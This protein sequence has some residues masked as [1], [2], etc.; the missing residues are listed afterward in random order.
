MTTTDGTGRPKLRDY[1][2]A[3]TLDDALLIRGGATTVTLRGRSVSELLVPLLPMLDGRRS[4]DDLHRELP[5]VERDVLVGALEILRSHNLLDDARPV[6]T[7]A[8]HDDHAGQRSY[9][10]SLGA[11]PNT[12]ENDLSQAT[13]TVVGLGETGRTVARVLAASGVGTLRLAHDGIARPEQVTG[14]GHAPPSQVGTSVEVAAEWPGPGKAL[15]ADWF[16]GAAVVVQC[17]ETR[18]GELTSM[19]ND[20]AIST[21]TP[22]LQATI[23]A[24]HATV[25]PFVVQGLSACHECFRLRLASNRSLLDDAV[26]TPVD[27]GR[28][29]TGTR[30]SGVAIPAFFSDLVGATA[31]GEVV[32]QLSGVLRPTTL[33]G[34]VSLNPHQATTVR[35]EVL[36]VPRCPV[37]GPRRYRPQM[38]IWDL[39]PAGSEAA[40][41]HR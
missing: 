37:C 14:D 23:G 19:L 34:F 5:W 33:G 40:D 28:E 16:E 15:P 25:G 12:V 18:T 2:H 17:A 3:R 4:V 29:A 11:D 32:R 35:H 7:P 39:D 22:F 41:G 9:W 30:S 24:D 38:K 8:P 1:L 26:G 13:V 36:K 20:T 10:T 31:A 27:L 21:G 6:V